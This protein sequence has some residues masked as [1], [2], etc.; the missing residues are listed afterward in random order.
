MSS[1]AVLGDRNADD[2]PDGAVDDGCAS[3]VAGQRDGKSI[4]Q[5]S[6][7]DWRSCGE[8]YGNF[9]WE[10]R[11]HDTPRRDRSTATRGRAGQKQIRILVGE[12]DGQ[13]DSAVGGDRAAAHAS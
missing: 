12:V 1:R 8:R 9:Q 6:I 7:E 5:G 4:G 11:W 13:R 3:G 2:L 10:I